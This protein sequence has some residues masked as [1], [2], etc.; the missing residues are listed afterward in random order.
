MICTIYT[1]IYIYS[2]VSNLTAQ[3]WLTTQQ[4][5]QRGGPEVSP[6]LTGGD[7][8]TGA[9]EILRSLGDE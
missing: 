6:L 8:A 3:G 4:D 2:G 1:Y 9:P 7:V 5:S